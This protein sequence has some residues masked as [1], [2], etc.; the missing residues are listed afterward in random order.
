MSTSTRKSSWARTTGFV[1]LLYFISAILG[2]GLVSK[3]FTLP[4]RITNFVSVLLYVALGILLYR[5]FRP[6]SGL[7]SVVAALCNFAGSGI[8]MLAF[9]HEGKTPISP[10]LFFGMYCFLIGVLILRSTFLPDALGFL[11]I[12]AGIGW[13]IFLAPLHIHLLTVAIEVLGF[14]A[15]AALMVWLVAKG[16]N[17]E[18]WAESRAA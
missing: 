9:F 13:F 14:I 7:L 10:L 2:Q 5:L 18:Q 6:V 15:E 11:N 12:A 4:G 8:T 16:V 17:E 3:G 1:Y